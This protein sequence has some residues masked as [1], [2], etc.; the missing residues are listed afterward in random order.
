MAW[1]WSEK[2]ARQ[3]INRKPVAFGNGENAKEVQELADKFIRQGDTRQKAYA[4]ARANLKH[5]YRNKD[6]QFYPGGSC[7][8]K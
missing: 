3:L 8:K 6:A 1:N 7:S 5:E 4:K 2:K